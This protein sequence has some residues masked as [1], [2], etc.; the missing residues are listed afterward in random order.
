MDEAEEWE[1]RGGLVS[2]YSAR[3]RRQPQSAR[4]GEPCK[5]AETEGKKLLEK[6]KRAVRVCNKGMTSIFSA[7]RCIIIAVDLVDPSLLS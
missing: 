2:L 7:F 4:E 5:S 6:E 3:K 1:K